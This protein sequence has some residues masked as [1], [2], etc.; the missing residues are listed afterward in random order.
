MMHYVLNVAAG[1]NSAMENLLNRED[2]KK[3]KARVAQQVEETNQKNQM[4]KEVLLKAG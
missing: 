4:L 2:L 3:V 1:V